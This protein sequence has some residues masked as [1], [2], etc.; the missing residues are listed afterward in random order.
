MEEEEEQLL[1][2]IR[3]IRSEQAPGIIK[4]ER[5]RIRNA[6]HNHFRMKAISLIR[7]LGLE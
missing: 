3:K 2:L 6:I 5:E 1:N 7:E 4:E